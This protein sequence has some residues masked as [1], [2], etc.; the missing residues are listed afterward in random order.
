MTDAMKLAAVL[1]KD[2][3]AIGDHQY[4]SLGMVPVTNREVPDSEVTIGK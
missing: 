1:L 2:E 3:L 4:D